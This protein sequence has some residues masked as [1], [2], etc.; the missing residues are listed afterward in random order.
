MC[1]WPSFLIPGTNLPFFG[2]T[3]GPVWIFKLVRV[4]FVPC[5]G[6]AFKQQGKGQRRRI[7]RLAQQPLLTAPTH[8]TT[9]PR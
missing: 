6:E 4:L 2:F 5:N 8:R 9:A 1:C 7:L 3:R